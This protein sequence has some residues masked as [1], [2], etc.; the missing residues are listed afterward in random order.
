MDDL[1]GVWIVGFGARKKRSNWSVISRGSVEPLE[2]ALMSGRGWTCGQA[3][4]S[5]ITTHI[6]ELE[7]DRLGSD[8][9]STTSCIWDFGQ[10]FLKLLCLSSFLPEGVTMG[11]LLWAG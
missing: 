11:L 9:S 2:A 1:Q 6:W 7:P 5:P 10:I 8:P 4:P 3:D